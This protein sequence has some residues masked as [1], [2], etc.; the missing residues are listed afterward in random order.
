MKPAPFDYVRADSVAEALALLAE[1]G[2]AAKLMAGGQSLIPML[3]FR[4]VRPSI[5]VDVGALVELDH[6]RDRPG[7]GMSIGALTRHRTLETSERIARRYPV[8]PEAMRH[9]AHLAIRNRGTIGGSLSHADPAA[10]LPMLARLLD[11][12]LVA[13]SARGRR[14]IEASD[15]FVSA[16]TT[17]LRD[18]EMLTH[19]ELPPWP[20]GAGWAFEEFAKRPG[21]YALAAV[22]ALVQCED[23]RIA[24]ARVAMMGI[25]DTPIR[26]DALERA[27]AGRPATAP[28]IAECIDEAA[29]GLSPRED[30]HASA[31]YRRMLSRTLLQR[32][33]AGALDR[34]LATSA[35]GGTR[36]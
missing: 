35:R 23:G 5:V 1:H 10:E 4:V 18:D 32:V 24:R 6:Q 27:M 36:T 12:R 17:A 20:P 7:G 28:G 11:A 21:D 34:A 8:I 19:V 16:L 9:V 2:S 13:E 22:G 29:R 15:F 25:A 26:L 31:G 3:N 33:T 30:L 14:E